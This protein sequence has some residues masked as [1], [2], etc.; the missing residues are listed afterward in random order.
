M[1]DR[2][3]VITT[4][5]DTPTYYGRHW[6]TS[7]HDE[8][9]RTGHTCLLLEAEVLGL[10]GT[11]ISEAVERVDVVV[12]FGHGKADRWLALPDSASV[13]DV[14]VVAASGVHLLDG[15]KVYAGCCRSLTRLGDEFR[16][17]CNGEFVG[18]KTPFLFET[19]N[20]QH[21]G[22]VVNRSVIS[23][24]RGDTGGK[25]AADLA[26]EWD[27]LRHDFSNGKLKHRPQASM[28]AHRA[29]VNRQGVGARP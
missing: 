6:A 10:S 29:D 27:S 17:Q 8:L 1:A 26:V 25:V 3:L 15:K 12:F 5:Y 13:P 21:F 20:H 2:V 4:A 16:K 11:A 18:Y 9:V 23:F 28:A 7:L 22:E 19:S 24:V 14:A